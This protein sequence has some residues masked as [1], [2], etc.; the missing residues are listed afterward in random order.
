[1][2]LRVDAVGLVE[3]DA[4][5]CGAPL[6]VGAGEGVGSAGRGGGVVCGEEI[7]VRGGFEACYGERP[8]ADGALEA[9]A[10]TPMST[11]EAMSV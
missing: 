10:G 1:M 3:L 7:G 2:E 6:A 5:F 8:D 4:D 11:N 9:A